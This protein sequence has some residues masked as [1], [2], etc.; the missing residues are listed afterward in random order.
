MRD[1]FKNWPHTQ[2]C[3]FVPGYFFQVDREKHKQGCTHSISSPVFC[4]FFLLVNVEIH[5]YIYICV[6]INPHICVWQSVAR[7]AVSES[8]GAGTSPSQG[9]WNTKVTQGWP[10]PLRSHSQQR[11]WSALGAS[12]HCLPQGRPHPPTLPPGVPGGTPGCCGVA[13]AT[14][15]SL[16]PQEF[17]ALSLHACHPL[18]PAALAQMGGNPTLEEIRE[19]EIAAFRITKRKWRNL[20]HS[21]PLRYWVSIRPYTTL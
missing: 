8:R 11:H 19:P 14:P 2:K 15:T 17:L 5:S 9:T 13:R 12:G 16:S 1:C 21:H 18:I 20:I 6:Y 7:L 4:L 3:V 10:L